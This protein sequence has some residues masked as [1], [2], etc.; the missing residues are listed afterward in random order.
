MLGFGWA[1]G[2][3]LGRGSSP[4]FVCGSTP[5]FESD[6]RLGLACASIGGF[7]PVLKSGLS[8]TR[9]WGE[10]LSWLSGATGLLANGEIGS[11]N[12]D[13]SY[14][15]EFVA[16]CDFVGADLQP[17]PIFAKFLGIFP[18]LRELLPL[19]FGDRLK[20]QR[21]ILTSGQLVERRGGHETPVC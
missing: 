15:L 4:S 19:L 5:G 10:A 8:T 21:A 9:V 20:S 7:G 2:G 11:F 1:S 17:L 18:A 14:P 13:G 12:R 16:A 3:K 6:S